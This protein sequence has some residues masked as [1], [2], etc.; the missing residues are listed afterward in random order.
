MFRSWIAAA[1]LSLL[2]LGS[3]SAQTR[4]TA[5]LLQPSSSASLEVPGDINNAGAVIGSVYSGYPYSQY[6]RNSSGTWSDLGIGSEFGGRLN[7]NGQAAWT[8]YFDSSGSQRAYLYDGTQSRQLGTLGGT[9]F[10]QSWAYGINDSGQV[11]GS[12]TYNGAST[13]AFVYENG[14]MQDIGVIAGFNGTLESARDINNSGQVVAQARVNGDL[15]AVIYDNGTVLDLGTLGGTSATALR[16][17]EA[18]QVIGYSSTADGEQHAFLYTAGTMMDLVPGA[19]RSTAL[20][21]TASGAIVGSYVAEQGGATSAF[22]YTQED[23]F[24][25]LNSLILGPF[26]DENGNPLLDQNLP[27][28]QATAI[29]DLGQILVNTGPLSFVL[30]PVP[31]PA[32]AWLLAPALMGLM[33]WPRRRKVSGR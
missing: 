33:A 17:N 19:F 7:E 11:V 2:A 22:I 3:A 29:N 14:A 24:M 12:S 10:D 28:M 1:A 9:P 26:V 13:H 8:A 20:G 16:I 21:I 25:D 32:A 30:T 18:G 31:L 23:G 15:R 5:I 6:L 27:L 4:Y